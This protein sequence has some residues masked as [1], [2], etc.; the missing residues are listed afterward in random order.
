MNCTPLSPITITYSYIN[1]VY[2]DRA[3]WEQQM[4][5]LY[6]EIIVAANRTLQKGLDAIK[7]V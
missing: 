3:R 5:H 6:E 7:E 2:S 4:Y 1:S